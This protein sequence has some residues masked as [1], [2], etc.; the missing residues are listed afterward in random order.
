MLSTSKY[1]THKVPADGSCFF[2]AVVMGMYYNRYKCF[3]GKSMLK[4]LSQMLR[5]IVVDHIMLGVKQ[6]PSNAN[7]L[8]TS[9]DTK[10][11]RQDERD[12]R[13]SCTWAGQIEVMTTSKLIGGGVVVYHDQSP[14]K[15]TKIPHMGSK[16]GKIHL[17]LQ[18]VHARGG[19]G[20]HF[21]L[22]LPK[23]VK[24]PVKQCSEKVIS[25]IDEIRNVSVPIKR[26]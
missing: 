11:I 18:G 21:E 19:L 1:M 16:H 12:M 5:H 15:F 7:F 3:P 8:L 10:S 6:N 20:T 4:T 24:K 23:T 17:L 22:I 13:K 2:H 25:L 14:T 9:D 26:T